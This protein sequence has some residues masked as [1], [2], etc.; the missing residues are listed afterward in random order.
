MTCN[1]NARRCPH[2][3]CARDHNL[4][5][6]RA[7]VIESRLA[8][9]LGVCRRAAGV[10][11]GDR[12]IRS[13]GRLPDTQSAVIRHAPEIIIARQQYEVMAGT[14]LRKTC[15]EGSDLYNSTTADVTKLR[16]TKSRKQPRLARGRQRNA[17]GT[18]AT[19][20]IGDRLGSEDDAARQVIRRG[21]RSRRRLAAPIGPT[22][23][24]RRALLRH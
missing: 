6:R 13:A 1:R 14:E 22:Y 8:H 19:V 16:R 23:H 11:A 3:N 21:E 17:M 4:H 12:N 24:L 15:V 10:T 9:E 2:R 7:P 18:H 5:L 20:N